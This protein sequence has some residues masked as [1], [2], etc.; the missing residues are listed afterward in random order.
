VSVHPAEKR[1]RLTG[2]NW[3]RERRERLTCQITKLESVRRA[4][5]G[6]DE[7]ISVLKMLL[8]GGVRPLWRMAPLQRRDVRKMI[9]L[10]V[11]ETHPCHL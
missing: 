10:P 11:S 3:A 9:R 8:K 5:W 2:W 6:G 7:N 4:H 1:N